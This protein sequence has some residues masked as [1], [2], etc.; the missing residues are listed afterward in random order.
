VQA[1]PVPADWSLSA[2]REILM[3]VE[4]YGTFMLRNALAIAVILGKED[5]SEGF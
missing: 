2:T 5:G 3:L 1:R 4:N